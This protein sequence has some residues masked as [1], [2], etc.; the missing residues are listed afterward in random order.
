MCPWAFPCSLPFPSN[1]KDESTRLHEFIP[2]CLE[3]EKSHDEL[4][5]KNSSVKKKKKNS[6]QE[7]GTEASDTGCD[8]FKQE[9]VS[10]HMHLVATGRDRSD[11]DGSHVW[12]RAVSGETADANRAK[13][14]K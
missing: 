7:V 6:Y 5:G 1:K 4:P 9:Q 12:R 14:T 8:P 11:K 3:K 2:P 13:C 10:P